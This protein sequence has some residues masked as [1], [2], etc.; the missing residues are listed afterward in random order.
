MALGVFDVSKRPKSRLAGGRALAVLQLTYDTDYAAGGYSL[1][2]AMCGM[3]AI[4]AVI[5]NPTGGYIGEYDYT[6]NKIKVLY[7]NNDAADGPLIEVA[8]GANGIDTLTARVL[9]IG[10]PA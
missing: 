9:V 1:T 2:A 7:G 4:H 3:S 10:E 6:A 8:D 5:V